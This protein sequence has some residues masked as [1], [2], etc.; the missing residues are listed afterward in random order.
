MC[1]VHV[2]AET[3]EETVNMVVLTTRF[4]AYTTVV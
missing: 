1:N 3:Y 2:D 4:M